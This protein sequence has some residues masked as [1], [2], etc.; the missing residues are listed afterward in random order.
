MVVE[1][2]IIAGMSFIA[3][4]C[5]Y[6]TFK[7]RESENSFG[8]VSSVVFFN[9]SLLFINFI[10]YT[11]LLVIQNTAS[12]SYLESPIM[13]IMLS[14][15]IWTTVITFFMYFLFTLLNGLKTVYDTVKENF[16]P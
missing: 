6:F 11:I 9:L 16:K 7:F 3:G 4:L 8:Q 14:I 1:N 5:G 12:V 13:N 15:T 2:G 10:V